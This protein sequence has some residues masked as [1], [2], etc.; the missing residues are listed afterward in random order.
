MRPISTHY[1]SLSAL[2]SKFLLLWSATLFLAGCDGA[3]TPSSTPAGA[4]GS[5]R[6]VQSPHA[7]QTPERIVSLAPNVTEVLFALGAGPRVVAV[8]RFDDYPPQVKTLP[9]VGG[10]IDVDLEALIAQKPDLVVGTSAGADDELRARL[11]AA[12]IAYTFVQ[13]NTL[14]EIYAGIQ[15][16]GEVLGEAASATRVADE[17]RAKIAQIALDSSPAQNDPANPAHERPG[18]LLVYGHDPMVA[19]GP[20][21]FGHE[22]LE[23][24]GGRNV[25]AGAQAPYP[26]L[27]V[28]KVLSLNPD[29]II[30]AT[31]TGDGDNLKSLDT[32]FWARYDSLAAVQNGRVHYLDDPILLRPSPRL[33]EGLSRLHKMITTDLIATE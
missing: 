22:L 28:E 16:F 11:D 9:K 13:M 19:A 30:D 12:N 26:T 29:C 2:L 25:L 6:I 8:T 4:A 14:D 18:V 17:M 7:A 23:L 24:A 33:V 1:L 3:P 10:I 21:S 5:S 15:K 32:T 27:D 31:V 20:G